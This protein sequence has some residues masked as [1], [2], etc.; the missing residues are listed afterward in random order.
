MKDTM[1]YLDGKSLTVEDVLNIAEKGYKVD[2]KEETRQAIDQMRKRLDEQIEKHPERKI[3]GTNVLH[4][5]LKDTQV[6]LELINEYQVKFMKVHNCGTGQPLPVEVVRAI[7]V[8]RLNSF[9]KNLSAMRLETCQLMID[10]LNRNVT[11]WVLEEGSVG[12]SGDLVPLAMIGA[13]LI[14]LPQAKAYY[15]GKLYGS[16]TEGDDEDGGS[17]RAFEDAGLKTIRLGA[18]EAMGLTNGSNFISAG[19]VFAVRDAESILNSASVAAA[20]SLEAIRGEQDAFSPLIHDNRP[21]EGQSHIAR[22]MRS[23]IH[24]SRRTSKESQKVAF[25][26][27]TNAGERVQD[28]YSFRAVP[29][30]HGSA[31]EAVKKLR[32]VVTIEINS[33]TDNPLF[34]LDDQGFLEAKSGANF[35]G[36]PLATVIDYVKISLTGLALISDK[37]SFSML[38]HRLSYGLPSDLAYD[39]ATAD[40]GLMIT[41]YAG[42]ARAAECRVL[43]T[44]AS[45]MSISTAANQ[46]DFVSMGSIGI[47]HLRKII[48]NIRVI[49][50]VEI[51]CAL[52]GIQ[53]TQTYLPG[54]LQGM[55]RG[56]A[57]VYEHLC[58]VLGPVG[59]DQYLRTDM[60]K[61]IA[62]VQSG[63]LIAW[64][65]DCLD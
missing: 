44:P 29:Q 9:A 19:A 47:L 33:A 63:D 61:A 25:P 1:I 16:Q 58:H 36:H 32:D 59:E 55:G 27:Q 13:V 7:M 30:V 37:R 4:G 49:L 28:R 34:T 54:D 31:Y 21:H 5:D 48:Q 53:L 57:A 8:I 65:A 39:L 26:S 3:Y 17:L 14:G 62:L 50:G 51:L 2:F 12:A 22:Q 15:N 35:H 60:E 10:M 45:V 52:R 41:Q 46:E 40:G 43:S 11:P 24:G 64:V 42:A 6:P 23:L 18:K 56:T 38:D 20:L